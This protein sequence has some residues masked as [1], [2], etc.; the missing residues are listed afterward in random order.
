MNEPEEKIIITIERGFMSEL[1]KYLKNN[2]ITPIK[3][4]DLYLYYDEILSG[5]IEAKDDYVVRCMWYVNYIMRKELFYKQFQKEDLLALGAEVVIKA[6]SKLDKDNYETFSGYLYVCI[7]FNLM[8]YLI[9]QKKH[10]I[11]SID[12]YMDDAQKNTFEFV[13]EDKKIDINK[14][15]SKLDFENAIKNMTELEMRIIIESCIDYLTI[16][17]IAQ[18]LN[19]NVKDVSFIKECA[20]KKLTAMLREYVPDREKD[21]D[22]NHWSVIADKLSQGRRINKY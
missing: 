17:E 4:E 7:K 2:K 20:L 21:E 11:L 15:V 1:L 3:K 8:N 9:R 13:L 12:A 19:M 6:L 18:K 5:N 22:F 10:K 16:K 14:Y